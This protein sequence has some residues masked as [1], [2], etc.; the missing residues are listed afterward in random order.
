[1]AS[2][3]AKS[4][5]I[6]ALLPSESPTCPDCRVATRVVV[7]SVSGDVICSECGL[8]FKNEKYQ[9]ESW[10]DVERT[11]MH[12]CATSR[13]RYGRTRADEKSRWMRRIANITANNEDW[14][15]VNV[16]LRAKD[17]VEWVL[18]VHTFSSRDQ[19]V[20]I[21]ACIYQV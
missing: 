18:D 4:S 7:D 2:V 16:A 1:M 14:M 20:V 11:S 5:G 17:Y 12:G 10:S 19:G 6:F 9:P 15:P 3:Y 13:S 21:A 8:V